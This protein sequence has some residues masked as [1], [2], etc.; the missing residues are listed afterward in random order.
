MIS[1]RGV[2]QRHYCTLSK[3]SANNLTETIKLK[4]RHLSTPGPKSY[5]LGYKNLIGPP[6]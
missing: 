3:N 6:L 4:I 2:K 1:Q 5:K